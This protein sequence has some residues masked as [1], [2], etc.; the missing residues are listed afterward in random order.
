MGRKAL[1][2]QEPINVACKEYQAVMYGRGIS[3][4]GNTEEE[5]GSPPNNRFVLNV[6]FIIQS[7]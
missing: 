3:T 7:V 5:G 2:K 4:A 1:W 6:W